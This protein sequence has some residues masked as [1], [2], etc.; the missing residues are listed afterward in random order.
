M[1]GI[2][3]FFARRHAVSESAL[4]RA[5]E[6]LRHRGPDG[7]RHWILADRRSGSATPG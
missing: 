3:A 4:T 2:V 7:R 6:S 5:T 1:C